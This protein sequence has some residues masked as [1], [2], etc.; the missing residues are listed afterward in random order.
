[1][2]PKIYREK[3]LQPLTEAGS[4]PARKTPAELPFLQHDRYYSSHETSPYMYSFNLN[5][6]TRDELLIVIREIGFAPPSDIN[7]GQLIGWL[8]EKD[9]NNHELRALLIDRERELGEQ[10]REL[11][12]LK[13]MMTSPSYRAYR[14]LLWPP[15]MLL[16]LWRRTRPKL[17]SVRR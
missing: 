13:Q 2:N 9:R 7:P 4:G 12:G 16:R 10:G 17:H 1:M 3:Y 15:R 8:K 11:A 6:L 5:K 14:A